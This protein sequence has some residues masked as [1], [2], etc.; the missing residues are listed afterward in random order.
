MWKTL[1]A[2]AYYKLNFNFMVQ[3][4]GG[5]FLCVLCPSCC[6]SCRM[7]KVKEVAQ[8]CLEREKRLQWRKWRIEVWW[9]GAS[10]GQSWERRGNWPVQTKRREKCLNTKRRIQLGTGD[11]RFCRSRE[12]GKWCMHMMEKWITW[13]QLVELEAGEHTSN[14]ATCWWWVGHRSG[15][16]FQVSNRRG[17]FWYTVTA[18]R[19]V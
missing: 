1:F 2:H 10:Y 4:S 6:F 3:L 7:E 16:Y 12:E 5:K 19:K 17:R 15:S 8:L 14:V 9:R 11:R 18:W 13:R